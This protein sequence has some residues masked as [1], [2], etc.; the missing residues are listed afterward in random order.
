MEF[1]CLENIALPPVVG[2]DINDRP[3]V[4]TENNM[5]LVVI[6]P[7]NTANYLKIFLKIKPK[8]TFSTS[9]VFLKLGT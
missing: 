9:S 1:F 4:T 7:Q 8:L 6:L 5:E 2:Y 3:D